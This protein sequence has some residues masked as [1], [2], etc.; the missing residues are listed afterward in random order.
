MAECFDAVVK[1]M[2][3]CAEQLCVLL[4]RTNET[5]GKENGSYSWRAKIQ[6]L[7]RKGL[8][9]GIEEYDENKSVMESGGSLPLSA[10]LSVLILHLTCRCR[11]LNWMNF[12]LT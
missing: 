6:G 11:L 3:T 10:Y 8:K 4:V 2:Y 7:E 12:K 1:L 9:V 5:G